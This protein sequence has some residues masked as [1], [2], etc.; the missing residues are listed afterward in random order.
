MD[1][2]TSTIIV[3]L[4]MVIT[5]IYLDFLIS[6]A[7]NMIDSGIDPGPRFIP[8]IGTPLICP[9][10]IAIMIAGLLMRQ[11]VI[12]NARRFLILFLLSELIFIFLR[13]F[14]FIW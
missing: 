10:G 2:S 1:R 3:G 13:I 12:V 14:G 9:L 4:L 8:F 6:L 7:F 5:G 11:N